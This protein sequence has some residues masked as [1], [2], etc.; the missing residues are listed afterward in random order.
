MGAHERFAHRVFRLRCGG[1]CSGVGAPSRVPLS[2]PA[3]PASVSVCM[4]RS[5]V[6]IG[7]RTDLHLSYAAL[8]VVTSLLGVPADTTNSRPAEHDNYGI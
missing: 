6:I 8:R 5:A 4:Y 7:C 1:Q 3:K 2:A